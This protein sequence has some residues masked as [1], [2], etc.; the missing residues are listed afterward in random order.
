[1]GI[2]CERQGFRTA[3]SGPELLRRHRSGALMVELSVSKTN[4][5]VA[6]QIELSLAVEAPSASEV[7]FPSMEKTLAHLS[8]L[9]SRSAL[10]ASANGLQRVR[11]TWVLAPEAAG[12]IA[13]PSLEVVCGS[14][15]VVTDPVAIQVESLLPPNPGGLEIRDIAGPVTIWPGRQQRM[16]RWLMIAVVVMAGLA[17]VAV[18]SA[19]KKR[20]A[21]L[22]PYESALRALGR[23]PE[24]GVERIHALNRILREYIQRRFQL[25]MMVKTAQEIIP[26]LERSSL[27]MQNPGLVE[28]LQQGEQIRFSN[29]VPAGYIATA[30]RFVIA[31]VEATKPSEEEA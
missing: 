13:I 6:G 21:E 14:D 27:S 18:R 25:P 19:M 11:R 3:A 10:S 1:L 16:F 24:S 30:E 7:G 20:V 15:T 29:R 8:M 22:P 2:G 28:F 26:E 23:M 17:G 31:F 12:M 9:D 5:A 4:I